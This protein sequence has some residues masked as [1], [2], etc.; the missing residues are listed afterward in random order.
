MQDHRARRVGIL[1]PFRWLAHAYGDLLRAPGTSLALGL[2]F[3]LCGAQLS[4]YLLMTNRGGWLP[5]VSAGFLLLAPVLATGFYALGRALAQSERPMLST[6]FAPKVKSPAQLAFLFVLLGGLFVFWIFTADALAIFV[7]SKVSTGLD[8]FLDY[9]STSREGA[10]FALV[11]TVLGGVLAAIAFLLSAVTAPML[12]D[13]ET[14]VLTAI[15]FTSSAILRNPGA[16]LLWGLLITVITAIGIATV[17]L[18]FVLVFPIIG[19][20]TWRA[21]RDLLPE[22]E[23]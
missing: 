1:A 19:L 13:K 23:H 7:G 11:G 8:G 17:F 5:A 10:N 22:S 21:Y 20:A 16:M 3:A 18:W 14:G 12:V 9:V 15:R 2:F 6:V 4:G